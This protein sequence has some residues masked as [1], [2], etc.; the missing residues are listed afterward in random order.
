MFGIDRLLIRPATEKDL[1]A[2]IDLLRQVGL[3]NEGHES[4][5]TLRR[6]LAHDPQSILVMGHRYLLMGTAFLVFDPWCS[7][8]YHLAIHPQLRGRGLGRR[9]MQ[10]AERRLRSRGAATISS[11]VVEGNQVSRRLAKKMG[12]DEYE[13]PVI[14]V[15]KVLKSEKRR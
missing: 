5:E 12:F 11:Y 8:I 10:Q 4:L 13:H 2:V 9:L 14:C 6:K 3:W 1:P 7:L 15:W